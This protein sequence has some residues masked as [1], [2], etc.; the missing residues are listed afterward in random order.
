MVDGLCT[1]AAWLDFL[2]IDLL[3]KARQPCAVLDTWKK[4]WRLMKKSTGQPSFAGPS[5]NTSASPAA[6]MAHRAPA[7]I[8][9]RHHDG[10]GSDDGAQGGARDWL[11]F[12]NEASFVDRMGRA[13]RR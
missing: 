11:M 7:Q 9:E 3:S 5:R 8:T 13:S 12:D 1:S 2:S 4:A 10:D 6:M